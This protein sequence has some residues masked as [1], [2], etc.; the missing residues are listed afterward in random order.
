MIKYTKGDILQSSAQAIVNTVNTVGIMGKGLALQFKM[1]YPENYK[2]YKK[3]C[4]EGRLTVGQMLITEE[5]DLFGNTKLI[6]NFP[7]KTTW[8]KPSEYVYIQQGL[9]ALKQEIVA[10][11]ILSIAIPPLGSRNGGLNWNI[12]RQMIETELSGLD[13][14]ITIYEPT[15]QIIERMD[16]EKTKLTP[17]RAMLLDVIC[18]LVA[19]GEFASEF[20]AEKIVYFLQRFGAQNIFKLQYQSGYYGPYSGKVRYV[21]RYLNGSYLMGMGE[22]QQKPFDPIWI[23]S[24]SATDA[25]EYLSRQSHLEYTRITEDVKQ[26]L[27]GYYSNFSLELIATLDFI[28]TH[29]ARLSHWYSRNEDEIVKLIMTDIANWSARKER[30]FS[31]PESI[32]KALTHLRAYCQIGKL[33]Y[34]SNG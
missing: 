28:L 12:V 19:N 30:L 4:D 3:A 18:N 22:L 21:L 31:D 16:A 6:V 25:K 23:L 7:T 29:D 32:R 14:D 11:G 24:N 5:K 2:I 33:C 20:A 27:A 8:R 10:R 34:C 13:C 26:F 1:A 9:V 15:E 17:A